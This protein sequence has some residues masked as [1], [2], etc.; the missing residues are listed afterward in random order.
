MNEKDLC[1][2]LFPSCL[3]SPCCSSSIHQWF[4]HMSHTVYLDCQLS[5]TG[6]MV[7]K[8]CKGGLTEVCTTSLL[9]YCGFIAYFNF[10]SRMEKD[11]EPQSEET[12]EK[13]QQREVR[14]SERLQEGSQ[15][16]LQATES[17]EALLEESQQQLQTRLSIE[18]P[19]EE[20]Q[21]RLEATL[22][23]TKPQKMV[24]SRN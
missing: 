2:S 4:H 8:D 17:S 15:K 14:S 19:L 20:L 11:S 21:Q 12:Q 23:L 18:P 3:L 1:L 9:Y 24:N 10:H 6:S 22:P 16:Q 5:L 13:S 7:V